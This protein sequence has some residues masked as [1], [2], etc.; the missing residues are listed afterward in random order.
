MWHRG[1][2]EKFLADKGA[3]P[4]VVKAI[5]ARMTKI[6]DENGDFSSGMLKEVMGSP[7]LAREFEQAWESDPTLWRS[8]FVGRE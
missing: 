4:A 2:I 7:E 6:A 5:K 1:S 3:K 8:S